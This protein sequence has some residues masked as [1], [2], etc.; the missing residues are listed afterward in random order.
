MRRYELVFVASPVLTEEEADHQV[1]VFE[2]LISEMGGTVQK[3]D[4]WGRRKLAFPIDKHVEG[5]YT[6]VLYDA[7]ARI[8]HELTRRLKLTDTVLRFLSVRADHE[9]LPTEDEK[10]ALQEARRDHIKRAAER[11]AAEAAGLP[12]PG[13]PGG[14]GALDGD[15]GDGWEAGDDEELEERRG[16]GSRGEEAE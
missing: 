2:S 3:V 16:R 13:G 6:L 4:R 7:E 8:E 9:K 15:D 14:P 10:L 12:L 11:A 1:T 5:N